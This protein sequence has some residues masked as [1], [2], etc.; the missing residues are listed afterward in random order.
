MTVND[1][2]ETMGNSVVQHGPCNDRV[3]LMKLGKADYPE[4][5]D[6][7]DRLA[8]D[9]GYSKIFAKIPADVLQGFKD[10]G[11][12]LEATI[13]G[14]FPDGADACF[15]GKYLDAPG[16]RSAS[17]NRSGKSCQRRRTGNLFLLPHSRRDSHRGLRGKTI[18]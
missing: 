7:L 6:H 13:P 1:I 3:Y 2:L 18:P 11:Y 12:R 16:G 9:R 4:I 10:E 8:A 15:L 5:V 14:F 17:L